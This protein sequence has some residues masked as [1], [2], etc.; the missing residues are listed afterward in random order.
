MLFRSGLEVTL[1]TEKPKGKET[2]CYSEGL[3]QYLK[4]CLAAGEWLPEDA[5]S[6]DFVAVSRNRKAGSFVS[7]SYFVVIALEDETTLRW[8]P[9]NPTMGSGDVCGP[10]SEEGERPDSVSVD[11]R[12]RRDLTPSG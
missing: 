7:P 8:T 2:W 12:S 10:G 11:R 5:F 3:E 9:P 4:E 1:E 6:G